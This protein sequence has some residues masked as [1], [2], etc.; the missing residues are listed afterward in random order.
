[1][2]HFKQGDVDM[3][4]TDAGLQAAA[5]DWLSGSTSPELSGLSNGIYKGESKTGMGYN[6]RASAEYR[7]TPKLVMGA[8][9]GADNASDYNQ[10]A[11]GLFLRYYFE[12]QTKL[13]D[14]PIEPYRSPYGVT[15]GR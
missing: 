5:V 1:M 13:M 12:P 3:F 8:T 2:Q 15:Y 14:L 9:V 4:P 7:F 11:G 10:W 6:V